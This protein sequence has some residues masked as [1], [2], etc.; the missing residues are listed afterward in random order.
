MTEIKTKPS[1]R[2]L[3]FDLMRGYFLIAILLDHLDFFPNGLD[4]V[5]MRG[6]MFV[7]AAEGFFLIS[8]IVLGIVRGVKLLD[9]PL[10]IAARLFL[11]RSVQLYLTATIL[12]AVFT[13]IGWWFYMNNPGL[14]Y[15]ILPPGTNLFEA[16]WKIATFQYLYGWADY[17]RLY[18]I[19]LLVSPLAMWLLRKG[20]WYVLLA[21]N[22][23][24]W[25]LYPNS[26]LLPDTVQEYWQPLSWQLIFFSGLTIGFYWPRI[27][28]W[29]MSLSTG[30][31]RLLTSGVVTVAVISLLV[32]IFIAFG[33]KM[34]LPVSAG[35][36]HQ[37]DDLGTNLYREFFDKEAMPLARII[38]FAFWFAASFW[39][40]HRLENYFKRWLG[41]LLIPFGQ[42]SLYV[43]TLSAVLLFF[44]HLYFFTSTLLANFI[45][46][47]AMILLVRLAIHYKVLMKIIPR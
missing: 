4:W 22:I 47:L 27:V 7:S 6:D 44:A 8:G 45:I 43:Y 21:V 15:G 26:P 46:S 18:C 11:K 38:L 37:L 20:L 33:A 35:L 31:R 30:L 13:L 34:L 29:W 19:F 36:A 3:T 28:A 42:N 1:S 39:L 17:L 24:V 5:S 9:R 2:V 41:W 16:V 25:L 40:F 23:G 14:K 12:T 32:N 10:E